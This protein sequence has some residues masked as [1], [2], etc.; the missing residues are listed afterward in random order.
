MPSRRFASARLAVLAGVVL[1][2]GAASPALACP[3]PVGSGRSLPADTRFTVRQPDTGAIRQIGDLLRTHNKADAALIGQMILTPQAVWLTGGTPAEVRTQTSRT[4]MTARATRTVPVFV[5]YNIPGRDCSQYS[6]GGAA[7][8]A[9]YAA[10]IDGVARGIGNQKAV[11]LLEPDGIGI[12]QGLDWCAGTEQTI[13]DRYAELNAAVDRLEQLPNVA[14][15]LDGTHSGWLGVGDISSRLVKA[16]VQRAQGLF[17]NVSN[18]QPTPNLVKYGTWI[19]KCIWFATDPGSWGL[20][21][22]DWCASQYYPA[23]PSDFSTWTLTD[24]W[25]TSNVESQAAYPGNDKLATHFVI[26]TSRNGQGPW[27]P[28]VSYPDPQVWCNP[29]DRGAGIQTTTKTGNDLIDAYLWVKIPGASDGQC[30]RGVSGSTTDPVWG[31]ISD[32]PAGT[33][34]PQM[35]LQLAKNAD[36]AFKR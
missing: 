32:P 36:P 19:S 26:D 30:N 21:H 10:W 8:A 33:W 6:A 29:I 23:T 31:G 11:V 9:A 1:V 7:D 15:Y 27:T 34:F 25:Y 28:A 3:T 2:L 17:L 18:F 13:A 24:A 5:A 4:V 14:V 35:A 12:I 22:F 20:G 16:G